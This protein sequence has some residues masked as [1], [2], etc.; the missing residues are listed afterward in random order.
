MN[1]DLIIRKA[2]VKDVADIFG[3]VCE[4]AAYEKAR[5]QV[6][7]G[8]DQYV[9]DFRNGLFEAFVIERETQVIGTTIFYYTY[10]TW[11]GKMIYLEDFI[12]S[13]PYRNKGY[14]KKLFLHFIEYCRSVDANIVRWQVLDWN[15]PA[16]RFYKKFP[17]QFDPEWLT[18]K[19]LLDP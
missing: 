11:R 5:D 15:E 14:G 12:I 13:Q 17:V 2:S 7:I 9:K 4:L 16:I 1:E 6:K 18:V 10:S 3:L 19:W 8:V